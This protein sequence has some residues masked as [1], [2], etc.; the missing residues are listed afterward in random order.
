MGPAGEGKEQEAYGVEGDPAAG[1]G[2][3]GPGLGSAGASGRALA[4]VLSSTC[5]TSAVPG[6][7]GG[8]ATPLLGFSSLGRLGPGRGRRVAASARGQRP[9]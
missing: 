1:G 9:S 2:S 4:G 7:G 6:P 3:G 8:A 5:L